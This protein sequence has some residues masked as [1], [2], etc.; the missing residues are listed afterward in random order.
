MSNKN[1][2]AHYPLLARV[3][4]IHYEDVILTFLGWKLYRELMK[5]YV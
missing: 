1:K 5:I 4:I 3:F 2:A